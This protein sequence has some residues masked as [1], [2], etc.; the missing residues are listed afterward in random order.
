VWS[1]ARYLWRRIDWGIVLNCL[2][3]PLALGALAPINTWDWPAYAGLSGLVVLYTQLRASGKRGILPGLF[4][5]AALAG[6]SYLLYSGFFRY[7]TPIFVGLGWSLGRTHTD[8]GEFL[9]VWGFF[10]FVTLSLLGMLV[11][12]L[13]SRARNPVSRL[14]RA[15]RLILCYPL[16]LNRLEEL[17]VSVSCPNL[18]GG[19]NS[20]RGQTP[21]GVGRRL[22]VLGIVVLVGLAAW[23]AFKGYWVLV[24]MVPLLAL[25]AALMVQPR[26]SD[27][28]RYVL[29]LV[30]TGFLILVGIEF[31]Y[32]KDHLDGDQQGWWRM[33]TLFKFYL[34]VWVMLG[35]AV[36]V[37]LPGLW[38][39]LSGQFRRRPIGV[40][41]WQVIVG[42]LFFAVALYPLLGTPARV[43]D[44]FPGERPPIGT[45][46]GMACMTVGQYTWPD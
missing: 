17:W 38:N 10:L 12:G 27:E 45:L 40:R 42:V 2:I 5:A 29:F 23:W 4:A 28:Q 25:A 20:N 18:E 13:R 31:F 33:N 43:L 37:S 44:R 15:A 21:S 1:S 46:D 6:A 32:L 36:G 19:P 9:T 3:W 41:A 22:V 34:Q 11:V 39:A 16:R 30:F 14:L 24:L 26:W 8:L 7:Y 35:L